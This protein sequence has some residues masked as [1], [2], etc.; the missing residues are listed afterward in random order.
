MIVV[1]WYVCWIL[2]PIERATA[3]QIKLNSI[4]ENTLIHKVISNKKTR[5]LISTFPFYIY[6]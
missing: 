4:M 6:S 3:A 2:M 1:S 5:M